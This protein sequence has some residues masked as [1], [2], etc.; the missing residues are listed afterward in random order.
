LQD[1]LKPQRGLHVPVLAGGQARRGLV[2]KLF[3]FGFEL[4]GVRAARLQDF[5]HLGGIYDREQQVLH[6][7]KFMPR[8][9][10]TG[11][12]IIQAKFQFLT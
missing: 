6:G 1:A 8:L 11:K 7:H 4:G 2:D 9:A 10:R 5:P 3:E 12:R